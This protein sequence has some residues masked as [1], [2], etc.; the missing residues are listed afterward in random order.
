MDGTIVA[1]TPRRTVVVGCSLM[2]A[3]EVTRQRHIEHLLAQIGDHF[4]RVGGK[5][6]RRR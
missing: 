4:E 2:E 5:I 3:Y 1:G 6:Q